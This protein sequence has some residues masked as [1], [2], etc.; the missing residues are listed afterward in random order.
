MLWDDHSYSLLTKVHLLCYQPSCHNDF[1]LE[2]TF[3]SVA[4]KTL[5]QCWKIQQLPSYKSS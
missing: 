2:I 1:R 3:E 4:T 5:F